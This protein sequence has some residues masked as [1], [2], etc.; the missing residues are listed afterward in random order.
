MTPNIILISDDH[1]DESSWI[2]IDDIKVLNE[3]LKTKT[4]ALDPNDKSLSEF[5]KSQL[6][7]NQTDLSQKTK[8][9][10][11]AFTGRPD[12]TPYYP[13]AVILSKGATGLECLPYFLE[14]VQNFLKESLFNRVDGRAFSDFQIMSFGRRRYRVPYKNVSENWTAFIQ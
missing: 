11:F 13:T 9:E 14:G 2:E 6:I 12:Y 4:L 1:K 5:Q 8:Q 3:D 7:I 10:T